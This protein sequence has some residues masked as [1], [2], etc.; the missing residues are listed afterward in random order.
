MPSTVRPACGSGNPA[1][2]DRSCPN[3]PATGGTSRAQ[4]QAASTPAAPAAR[5]T[6]APSATRAAASRLDV[7]PTARSSANCRTRRAKTIRKVEVA[8]STAA[9]TAT[10]RKTPASSRVSLASATA[11]RASSSRTSSPDR[12]TAP[13]TARRIRSAAPVAAAGVSLRTSTREQPGSPS[14]RSRPGPG[15]YPVGSPVPVAAGRTMP[16]ISTGTRRVLSPSGVGSSR[17]S[18]LPGTS[19]YASAARVSTANWRGPEGYAPSDRPYL[20]ERAAAGVRG[21]GE[22]AVGG[23]PADRGAAVDPADGP[24][25]RGSDGCACGSASSWACW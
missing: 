5:P 15:A 21:E 23:A 19:P 3:R 24:R 13:G 22:V 1:G 2:A 11:P 8:T 4:P 14:S 18:D 25:R 10:A 7:A 16:V 12:T 9:P 20:G 6:T 17:V